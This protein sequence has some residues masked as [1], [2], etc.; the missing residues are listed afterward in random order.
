MAFALTSCLVPSVCLTGRYACMLRP[1]V[2]LVEK[3][4]FMDSVF[5]CT[6]RRQS[7]VRWNISKTSSDVPGRVHDISFSSDQ[8]TVIY[9]IKTSWELTKCIASRRNLAN[10]LVRRWVLISTFEIR[11]SGER[12]LNG[13]ANIRHAI[14]ANEHYLK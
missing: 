13:V 9:V 4:E 10:L 2:T 3:I 1:E 6:P 7:S 11:K 8:S 5:I 12:K 14:Y